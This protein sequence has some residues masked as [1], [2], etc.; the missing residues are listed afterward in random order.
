M[1]PRTFPSTYASNGQQQMVV[2]FLSSVTGLQ[3]WADYIPVRLA[4]GGVENS[5]NNN[6]Y[7][8]VTVVSSPT[9]TQQAWKEYIPVYLDDSATDAWLVNS[10]GYI[11]Y[12]YAL[13]G[14][15][16]MI[17]DMTNTGAL[18]SRVTFT[19]TTTGT[20]FNSAGTLES[21]AIDGPR[22][23]YNPVTL[24]A[25]GLLIEE[26]RTNLFTYSS[27]FDNAAWGKTRSSITAN[28]I[29]APDGTLTGDK[30]VED[31]TANNTHFVKQDFTVAIGTYV[32]SVFAKA[33]ERLI[34]QVARNNSNINIITHQ[35]NL[36]TGSATGAG[37][38]I[39]SVGNGW[40]RCVGVI[41][42]NA[43]ASTGLN[44]SLNNGS[45]ITYTGDGASGLYIWGAQ[46][47]AGAFSTSYIPTT[48][49]AATRAPD[50]ATMT[51]TNFSDWYNASEGALFA[52]YSA[53]VS[54]TRTV[55][56]INDGTADES[57][58]LRTISADPK[59]TVTD[60]G[61]DQADIDA[62]SVTSSVI[63]KF[64][65]AYKLDDFAVAI[66]GGTVGTDTSG[67]LPTVNQMML[68]NSAA[69]NYLNGY[70]RRVAYFPTR[71]SNAQLQ[72][73]TA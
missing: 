58:R 34:L 30:L 26:Q 51:G 57:I 46:L 39:T 29:T 38:S 44:F 71:I 22:F 21:V 45:T 52:E 32:Y 18:D 41:T 13:F 64:A 9:A 61:V 28:A 68:G 1:I 62:G 8:D 24:A 63:Y 33:G 2:Y 59:F 35:F 20:R 70:L 7:I 31:T 67:T 50:V 17:M 27:E 3:R 72:A 69:A 65:G 4:Q 40:Y 6:G 54:G 19:R 60:G 66:N 5:Y 23:D 37:A 53:V 14:D 55:V 47:E 12:S 42:V 15:A 43:A 10:V 36:S 25:R 11:P 56:A 16:S 49:A 48:T 73:V